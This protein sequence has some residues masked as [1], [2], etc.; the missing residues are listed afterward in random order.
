MS[1]YEA[2]GICWVIFTSTLASI[3]ILYLAYVGF[4]VMVR[5]TEQ[6]VRVKLLPVSWGRP[7]DNRE[8]RITV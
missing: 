1:V 3:A 4:R 7:E 2:I 8:V 5:N 6:D